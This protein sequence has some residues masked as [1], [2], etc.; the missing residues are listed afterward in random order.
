MEKSKVILIIIAMG[1]S[2][3]GS[4]FADPPEINRAIPNSDK[5]GLYEKFELHIDMNATFTNPFDPDELDLSTEFTAPSGKKWNIW[6]FYNPTDWSS[7]WMVRFSPNET[8]TWRYVVKVTDTEGTASTESASFTTVL[9]DNPG[10]ITIAPN[11]RYLTHSNGSS[12][13]GVGMWYNDLYESFNNGRITEQGLNELKRRGVNFIS[14]FPTPF[15]TMATGLGRYDENRCGRM[16]QLFEWCEKRDIYISWNIWFHAYLSETVWSGWNKKYRYNPYKLIT[17]AAD[18]FSSEEAWK[19]QEKLY[20]Y[21]IARWG[22]NSHL[23]LWFIVDEINGTDGWQKNEPSVGEAW[24]RKIHNYFKEN[25]PWGRPTTGTKS[26]GINEYWPEG[27]KIFD[28]A[29]REIYEAQGHPMPESGKLDPLSESAIHDSYKNYALWTSKLWD[30]FGKPVIIGECGY[31]HTYYEPGMPGYLA[32]YHNAIWAALANGACATPFW[33]AYGDFINDSVVTNQM[34]YFRQFVSNIDFDDLELQPAEISAGSCDVYA[35]KSSE[36]VFGWAVNPHTSVANETFTL[37]G[38][39]DG[40]YEVRLYRTWRGLYL[41]AETV[42]CSEGKLSITIPELNTTG[43]HAYHIG[44][45]VAFMV[46][47]K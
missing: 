1:I 11:N 34:L 10:F 40:T 27:Y 4:V 42:A 31:D 17:S 20:R 30:L 41:D 37:T 28:I 6:G 36:I 45:D 5:I 23:F 14:F 47:P 12:F 38:I 35:M 18:F 39:P 3:S 2:L 43:G 25:D 15:E 7:R 26:G 44:N 9:S 32:M 29:A 21:I 8:G 33:W 16:D 22:Y 24:C 19:Y 46:I 13:Y